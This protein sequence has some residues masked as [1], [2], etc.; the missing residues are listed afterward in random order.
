MNLEE[1]INVPYSGDRFCRTFAAGILGRAGIPMPHVESPRDAIGWDRV[2]NPRM[3]DIVVFNLA[4]KPS[5][6]GVCIGRGR[7]IHVEEGGRSRI[8]ML[9]SSLWSSRIE[10]YYRYMEES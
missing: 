7:F 3:L 5:H 6:V 2:D 9:S 8:E 1:F 10:G 4:G